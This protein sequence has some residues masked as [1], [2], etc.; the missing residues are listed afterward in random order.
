MRLQKLYRRCDNSKLEKASGSEHADLQMSSRVRYVKCDTFGDFSQVPEWMT[1]CEGNEVPPSKGRS[2]RHWYDSACAA[3]L[4][5]K[6]FL[7]RSALR[8][9]VSMPNPQ[10]NPQSLHCHHCASPLR[11]DN[12]HDG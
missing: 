1:R 9:Y 6:V 11:P 3:P 2:S 7:L 4:R 12:T 10:Q 8:K 5:L